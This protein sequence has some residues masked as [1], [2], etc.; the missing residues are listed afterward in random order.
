MRKVLL[1][2]FTLFISSIAFSQ[3]ANRLIWGP[4]YMYSF[5]TPNGWVA[6]EESGLGE[7][8]NVVLYPQ[9]YNWKTARVT[10][11]FD[12]I[13]LPDSILLGEYIA[14]D[15]HDYTLSTEGKAT[16]SHEQSY[17]ITS[18]FRIYTREHKKGKTTVYES[19]AYSTAKGGIVTL[20]LR[21][22]DKKLFLKHKETMNDLIKSFAWIIDKLELQTED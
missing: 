7:G 22:E 14:T 5:N 11:A 6:D 13:T 9:G 19:I 1:A 12:F 3:S 10:M 2:A 18:F 16:Y 8:L 21:T 20:S 15:N 4:N 17:N